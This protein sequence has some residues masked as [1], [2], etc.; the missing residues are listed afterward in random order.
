MPSVVVVDHARSFEKMTSEISQLRR[1]L[2]NKN[3]LIQ[4]NCVGRFHFRRIDFILFFFLRFVYDLRVLK[5]HHIV[6]RERLTHIIHTTRTIAKGNKP[7]R[8]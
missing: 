3:Q 2:R 6:Q 1:K 5:I 8:G 4:I 7:P